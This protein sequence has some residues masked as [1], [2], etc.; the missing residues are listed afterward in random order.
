L[1]CLE[2]LI[3]PDLLSHKYLTVTVLENPASWLHLVGGLIA[4]F[5]GC[6]GR[7][8]AAYALYQLY[9]TAAKTILFPSHGL[10]DW[11]WDFLGDNL[12][13]LAGIGLGAALA[14]PRASSGQGRMC[15][16][17][18]VALLLGLLTLAWLAALASSLS[19]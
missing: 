13:F 12:E 16:W 4:A 3:W 6:P 15:S 7:Y 1:R 17:R 19:G 8:L 5:F 18:I 10:A 11:S 2:G 14:P 9:T